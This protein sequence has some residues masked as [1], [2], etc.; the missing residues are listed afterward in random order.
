MLAGLVWNVATLS[1]VLG[2]AIPLA[3]IIGAFWYHVE[4]VKSNNELKR[5]MIEQ[6][7]S[8]EEIERVMAAGREKDE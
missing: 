3:A 6:G 7:R 8:V 4:K 2:C 1:I 5:E